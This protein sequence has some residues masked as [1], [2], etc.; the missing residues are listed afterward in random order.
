[1]QSLGHAISY[2][3]ANEIY[4][5]LGQ[6]VY[7]LMKKNCD[8]VKLAASWV[9]ANLLAAQYSSEHK[10]ELMDMIIKDHG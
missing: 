4:D 9:F 2:F 6:H 5:K 8:Q 10:K 7:E 3:N 1:L